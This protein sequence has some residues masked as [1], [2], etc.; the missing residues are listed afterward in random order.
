MQWLNAP[1]P[2]LQN[3][4]YKWLFALCS[5]IFVFTFLSVFEPYGSSRLTI[6]KYLFLAGFGVAVFLGVCVTYFILP[7]LLPLYLPNSPCALS[8]ITF[9]LYFFAIFI[10]SS[11]SQDTPA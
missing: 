4:R 7:K 1:Y 2:L 11:I 8:S 5:G 10:I 6:D 9:R 3:A